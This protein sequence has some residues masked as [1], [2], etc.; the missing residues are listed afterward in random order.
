MEKFNPTQFMREA[1]NEA[2][3]GKGHVSPNPIVGA[4]VVLN[5]EII[6]RGYHQKYGGNHA[7]VNAINDA[8]NKGYDLVGAS[9]FINLEPCSHLDKKTPP[10]AP[11]I[12]REK[13]KDVYISNLD[14]NPKVSGAGIKLLID[15]G[16]IVHS[17]ILEDEGLKLNEVFFKAMTRKMPFVHLKMAQTIDGKIAS[18]SGE[19]KY[20]SSS[21]SLKYVHEL[22]NNYDAVL[23]GKNTLLKDNPSLTVRHIGKNV[24]HPL[25]IVMSKIENLDLSLKLFSDE[26]RRNTV[27][28][29][30]SE[31][32]NQNL[33][34]AERIE[35]LGVSLLG[36]K[37]G[38]DGHVDLQ[39]FLKTM[40]SLKIFSI[41]I[42][43]GPTIASSFLKEKLVDKITIVTAPFILGEGISTFANLGFY[44]FNSKIEV[45][46]I[47]RFNLGKDQ[48]LEGYLCSQV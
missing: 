46:N 7:E 24:S 18:L 29:T 30:T 14:P 9:I 35:K 38:I 33:T 1:F 47:D 8:K 11:L 23:I 3:K 41:L 44:D 32:L 25:R 13:F 40:Y 2:I 4:I 34:A 37:V 22:R 12:V 42:E 6:G 10:C 31:D 5:G 27:I 17:G 45:L 20:I 36:L 43:G 48:V 39:S 21:E 28:V 19:S 16:I 26:Y 15:N